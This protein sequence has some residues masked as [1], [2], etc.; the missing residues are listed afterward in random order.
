M[1]C[2][3]LFALRCVALRRT[4]LCWVVLRCCVSLRR[5]VVLSCVVLYCIVFWVY[6][7]CVKALS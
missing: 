3:E 6:N 4:V 1:F 7:G 5:G 2:F